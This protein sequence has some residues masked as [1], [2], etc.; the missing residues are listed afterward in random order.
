MDVALLTEIPAFAELS[1]DERRSI[2]TW[3]HEVSVSEGAIVVNEGDYSYEFFAIISGTAEVL[4]G[5]EKV[6]ELGPGDFF[7]EIGVV[8]RGKRGATVRATSGMRLMTLTSWDL[9]RLE[10]DAP[11]ATTAIQN[12]L[13]A[14]KAGS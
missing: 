1:D 3:A 9:R 5:G 11:G 7:G 14:R 6:A 12:V 8:E 4:R 10:K 2:A 13:E